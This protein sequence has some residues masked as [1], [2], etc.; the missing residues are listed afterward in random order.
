MPLLIYHLAHEADWKAAQQS[1]QYRA[2]SL[3]SE[4]F[5]HCA[6]AQQLRGV[7]QR[8]Y[9]Q[10]SQIW[11]LTLKPALESAELVWEN[12][13]GGRELFPHWYGPLP[14]KLITEVTYLIDQQSQTHWPEGF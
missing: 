5:I 11:L 9:Q 8:Y 3:A 2:P 4:G 14:L 7:H 12:T 10:A 13:S 6:T 1:G